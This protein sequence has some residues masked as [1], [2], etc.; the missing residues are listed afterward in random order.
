MNRIELPVL[1]DYVYSIFEEFDRICRK[2]DIKYSMEGGTL[3][4]AAKFQNFVPWDD[5]IDVIMVRDQYEKF[6]QVAPKELDSKFFLESYNSVDEF[7][8]NYAKLCL[9]GTMICDYDY[10]H[11]KKMNHGIFMDIFPIDN[12]NPKTLRKHCS[13]VGILTGGR[14]TKLKVKLRGSKFRHF[15]YKTVS[16][17]P[18]SWLIKLLNKAC[19]FYSKKDT[20]YIYEVCNSNKN[21]PPMPA[22]LYAE[23]IELP[24][25]DKNFLAIKE[26][27]KLLKSRFGENYMNEL[28]PEEARKPSHNQN[29][30][31]L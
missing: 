30:K 21:F 28:P 31:I 24:F 4:G 23:Y 29:I 7:P 25:R 3:M 2:Y 17:L 1:Q 19:K 26:Y 14:K 8:L 15:V 12:V 20:G 5:D 6:M 13:V 10:S 18:M 27:D 9:N 22:S 11:L 16:L